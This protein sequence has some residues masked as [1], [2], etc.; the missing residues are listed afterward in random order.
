MDII[1]KRRVNRSQ[2]P[3]SRFR[4]ALARPQAACSP[5]RE[6]AEESLRL[7]EVQHAVRRYPLPVAGT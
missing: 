5:I 7:A 3:E 6:R 4:L 1:D 2:L